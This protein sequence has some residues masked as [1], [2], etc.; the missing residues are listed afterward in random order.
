MELKMPELKLPKVVTEI[1]VRKEMEAGARTIFTVIRIS[2]IATDDGNLLGSWLMPL[3]FLII[4]PGEQYAISISGEQMSIEKILEL[5]P[6]L[7]EVI[8]KAR[9]I[10]R[11]RVD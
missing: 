1:R 8:E 9:G 4:E 5:A 6:S 7:K 10:H 2:S 3:A 11:I